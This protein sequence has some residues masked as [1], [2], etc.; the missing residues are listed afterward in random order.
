MSEQNLEQLLMQGH[1]DQA[2]PLLQSGEKL[3][4]DLPEH[5]KSQILERLFSNEQYELL[6]QLVDS[7]WIE[8]DVYEFDSFD[9]SIFGKIIWNLKNDD[10]AISFFQDFISKFENINDEVE[11][12]TLLGYFL[13]KGASVEKIKILI[14]AGCDINFTNNAEENF[15]HQVIRTNL[16]K[17]QLSISYL[18]LLINEGLDV[19]AANIVKKT[20]LIAAIEFNKP[21]YLDILLQNGANPNDLDQDGN[22]AIYYAVAHK[23]D[24]N[25]YLKLRDFGSPDFDT[26]NKN[27]V[28]TLFEYLRMMYVSDKNLELLRNLISDGA[29]IYQA[30]IYYSKEKTPVDLIAEKQP[31]VLQAILDSG[32]LDVN[33]QD[34]HGNTLLHKVCAFNVNFEAEKAKE[35]YKKVKMLLENGADT[36]ISND[37]DKTPLML[38]S[39]DNLKIKTVELLMK[40]S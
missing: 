35:T 24:L 20:P 36:T 14:D 25:I 18:E 28:T 12:K 1:Y 7:K 23:Q 5:Q 21:E 29:D 38:A 13:E 3:S 37:E 15:I 39:D 33:R 9:K 4:K 26:V 22:S 34:D 16:M 27:G 30:S 17:P 2:L 32:N 40:N 6:N 8:T 31:E 19:N 11:A 10:K